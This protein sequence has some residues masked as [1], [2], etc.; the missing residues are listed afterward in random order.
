MGAGSTGNSERAE[1]RRVPKPRSGVWGLVHHIYA[2]PQGRR[3]K[4][5]I[6]CLQSPP[7]HLHQTSHSKLC[8]LLD[9]NTSRNYLILDILR[10]TKKRSPDRKDSHKFVERRWPFQPE[11]HL[12]LCAAQTMRSKV[13]PIP[14]VPPFLLMALTFSSL[15]LSH[16]WDAETLC[17]LIK[18]F[19]RS[20]VYQVLC[21]AHVCTQ[22]CRPSCVLAAD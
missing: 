17:G 1:I 11:C 6:Q 9:F 8:T 2:G 5:T 7:F 13:K 19:P 18:P 4:I 15:P 16:S 12:S 22:V 20:P 3:G 10:C 14:P 21:C